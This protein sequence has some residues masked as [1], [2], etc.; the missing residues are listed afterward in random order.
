M[1]VTRIHESNM[2]RVV[3]DNQKLIER[4]SKSSHIRLDV[5]NLAF[6][7][8]K[9]LEIN[10]EKRFLCKSRSFTTFHYISDS[11]FSSEIHFN[12]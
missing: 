4:A 1:W 6:Y 12:R 8:R 5:R 11:F 10:A 3:N 7:Y 9:I 2:T